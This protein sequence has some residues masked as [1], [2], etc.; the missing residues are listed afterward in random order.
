M[1]Q[2]F[3]LVATKFGQDP[4]FPD[5]MMKRESKR[6]FERIPCQPFPAYHANTVARS[7]AQHARSTTHA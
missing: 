7:L 2:K 3:E 6:A 5:Q 1:E 4:S